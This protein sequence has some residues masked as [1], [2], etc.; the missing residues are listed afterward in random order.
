MITFCQN[1][2]HREIHIPRLPLHRIGKEP[3]P[4]SKPKILPLNEENIHKIVTAHFIKNPDSNRSRQEIRQDLLSTRYQLDAE[5]KLNKMTTT[6]VQEDD[7]LCWASG[8]DSSRT[9]GPPGIGKVNEP[10]DP[11]EHKTGDTE[12]YI[13]TVSVKAKGPTQHHQGA[14]RTHPPGKRRRRVQNPTGYTG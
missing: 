1:R 13:P 4:T 11:E 3:E 2:K 10:G 7:L 8:T 9:S 5:E 14:T 6:K 12:E